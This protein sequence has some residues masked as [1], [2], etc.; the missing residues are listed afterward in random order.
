MH[1]R[2]PRS[3]VPV[4]LAA[5]LVLAPVVLAPVGVPDRTGAHTAPVA[6]VAPVARPAAQQSVAAE[7]PA[8]V[9]LR[10]A[11][12]LALRR[13]ARTEAALPAGRF[14]T[15][16][17]DGR[18]RTEGPWTGWL[19][20]FHP[21]EL[22]TAYELSGRPAWARLAV[23]RQRALAARAADGATHDLGFLL[24]TG[25]GRGVR[26]RGRTADAAV[27]DRAAVSLAGRWVPAA[28]ALRS[29]DGPPGEVTVIV[30]S[31][32]NLELLLAAADRAD[33]RADDAAASAWRGAALAHAG[34]VARVLVRPDGST[35]HVTRLDER[36]GDVR[37]AG[38]VQ[39]LRDSSTWARGQSW[40]VH[41]FTT[42]W[43][44]SRDPAMLAVA[45]ATAH[46][47]V[48]HLPADGVPAW[49]S[50][51]AAPRDA[52]AAAVLASGLLELARL[53]PDPG[54]RA[55]WTRAGRR[56]LHGL[57]GP[58]YLATGRSTPA[59]LRHVRHSPEHPDAGTSYADLY[60]LEAMQR[61]QLLPSPRPVLRVTGRRDPAPA[62]RV[63]DLGR[64]RTVSAVSVRWAAAVTDPGD[65]VPAARF[66]VDTSVDGRRWVPGRSAVGSGR[67]SGFET[68]DVKDRP[69]RLVRL[70]LLGRGG[71]A[72]VVD[73]VRVRGQST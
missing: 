51:A 13:L 34:T 48:A 52:S 66:R 56:V 6:R 27:L 24:Q 28:H 18:W 30:D 15:V 25:F 8:E 64:V 35:V 42:V 72:A 21:G 38:T 62:T 33:A 73:A 2:T 47:A 9:R 12:V 45:R 19:A 11:R 17:A 20:G 39:G 29:W 60:L 68:Y 37:W 63:L 36:T 67:W 44:E 57:T 50:A 70:T 7:A 16:A 54:L 59:L 61:D 31:M 46:R 14:P 71:S 3:A 58:G 4:A 49:D 69:A 41:G 23:R 53:D 22:W 26:L 40:A 10:Q 55:A 32:V 43:R 5:L 65:A 1:G